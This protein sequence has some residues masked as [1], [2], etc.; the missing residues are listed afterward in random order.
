MLMRIIPK[1]EDRE[2]HQLLVSDATLLANSFVN[3]KNALVTDHVARDINKLNA[4]ANAVTDAIQ[5]SNTL[6]QTAWSHSQ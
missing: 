1:E 3:L 2:R 4:F 6:W 5:R